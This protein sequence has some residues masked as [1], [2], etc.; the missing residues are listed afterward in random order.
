MD[1]K[2]NFNL[3]KIYKVNKKI[4][5]TDV[6]SV[7]EDIA[8]VSKIAVLFAGLAATLA[9]PAGIMSI[10]SAIG[11]VPRPFIIIAL[12]VFIVFAAVSA[13]ISAGA[14]LYAKSVREKISKQL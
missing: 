1:Y 4:S 10:A 2:K 7:A 5:S 6:V 14:K 3:I 9:A 12:P 11:L 13:S 8:G